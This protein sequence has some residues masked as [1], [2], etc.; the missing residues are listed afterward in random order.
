ML[1]KQWYNRIP[2]AVTILFMIIVFVTLLTYILPAGEFKREL[3]EGRSRVIPG[4]YSTIP[5]TPIGFLEMFK[6][7]PLGFKTAIEVIF[8]V[9][10]GGIMFGIIEETKAIENAVGTFIYKIG[11]ENPNSAVSSA[12]LSSPS[13]G[14]GGNA[15]SN[16]VSS[17]VVDSNDN[18]KRTKV[19]K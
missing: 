16:K 19:H 5:N 9:L 3:I 1:T 15:P 6:A 8:V 18:K 7:I 17:T 10:S 13:V 12:K 14:N 4:S 2:H 11:Q